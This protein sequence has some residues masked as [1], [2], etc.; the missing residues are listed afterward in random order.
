MSEFLT[1]HADWLESLHKQMR[2]ERVSAGTLS[3]NACDAQPQPDPPTGPPS[4]PEPC[5]T[6]VRI[7]YIQTLIDCLQLPAG[8]QAACC[9]VAYATYV[10]DLWK[11][12][13]GG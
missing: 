9:T 13:T 11:C 5:A 1:R 6:Q 12:V 8:Q 10:A 3:G 7:K 4:V 2:Q